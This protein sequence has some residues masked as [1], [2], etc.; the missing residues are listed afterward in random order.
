MLIFFV[1]DQFLLLHQQAGQLDQAIVMYQQF[2]DL[3]AWANHL[4]DVD[5][6]SKS[7]DLARMPQKSAF[8]ADIEGN[9]TDI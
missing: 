1:A 7:L 5:Q 4:M 6:V 3:R 9:G 8:V 2:R